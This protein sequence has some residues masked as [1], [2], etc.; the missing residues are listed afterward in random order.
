MSVDLLFFQTERRRTVRKGIFFIVGLTVIVSFVAALSSFAAG[1]SRSGAARIPQTETQVARVSDLA[2]ADFCEILIDDGIAADQY[3]SFDSGMGIAVY[4][5]PAEC[6][7]GD[8]YPFQVTGARLYLYEPLSAGYLW[9]VEVQVNIRDVGGGDKCNGPDTLLSSETF[10]VPGDSAYPLMMNLTLSDPCCVTGPFFLEV[11]YLSQ[12]GGSTLPSLVMDAALAT[13]TDTCDNWFLDAGAYQSWADFW[14]SP[15]LGDAIIRGTGYEGSWTCLGPWCWKPDT[16]EALS[17]T[18]DFSQRQFGD[19]VAL[20]APSAAANCLQWF[21][22]LPEGMTPPDFI[23]LLSDYFVSHPDS[24]TLVGSI[25]S[26]LDLYFADYDLLLEASLVERPGFYE[27]ADLVRECRNIILLLGFWQLGVE[28]N[29]VGGHFVSLAGICA[30]STKAAFSD[31]ARDAAADGWQGRVRPA[32]Y[33]SQSF[34]DTL[35]NDPEYVSH[36][37]YWL[38]VESHSGGDWRL[39]EYHE[40]QQIEAFEGQNFQLGQ[41]QYAVAYDPVRPTYT[42]VEYAILIYPKASAI[43]DETESSVPMDFE[44]LQNHPNPFNAETQIRYNL[45]R[46][47]RVTLNVYNTLGQKVA[48]L[49]EDWQE[50]G[51]KTI[52][53]DGTD[54]KGNTLASGVYLYQLKA[55]DSA[56]SRRMLLLK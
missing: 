45:T 32:D 53:W 46:P 50:A 44:L 23:R 36:D 37:I 56:Q 54:K 34:S 17:G 33:F 15:A 8:P 30:D 16:T 6:G 10:T 42:E 29:R 52:I 18:P 24:G 31:P 5:D 4:M 7:A 49:V 48:T 40:Y 20:C 22:A 3:T 38:L 2:S 25:K 21:D 13:A 41:E 28:W 43:G 55:G 11:V 39:V 26:G 47:G 1:D 35:H 19:S 12:A 9:P 14:G 51:F 27:T